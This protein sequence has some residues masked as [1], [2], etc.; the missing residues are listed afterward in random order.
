[1]IPSN[2]ITY[3]ICKEGRFPEENK[4]ELE[5]AVRRAF[6]AQGMWIASDYFERGSEHFPEG[7]S[8]IVLAR[9]VSDPRY[10]IGVTISRLLKIRDD[11]GDSREFVLIDKLAVPPE[12]QGNGYYKDILI[13]T[14]AYPLRSGFVLPHILRTSSP[15][16]DE[17][18]FQASDI[19]IEG[20]TYFEHGFGFKNED[21]TGIMRKADYWF[22]LAAN[23]IDS[24]PPTV[25]HGPPTNKRR[26][27]RYT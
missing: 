6:K 19:R 1:M 8:H 11:K 4:S 24:M 23:F 7:L 17:K 13:H 2:R 9:D 20:K 10:L 21:G 18:Y 25:F 3:L 14:L 27:Y 16:L 22:H 12:S 15:K 5:I 26:N